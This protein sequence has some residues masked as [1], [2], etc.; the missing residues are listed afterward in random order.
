IRVS[1]G[2]DRATLRARLVDLLEALPTDDPRV[3]AARRNLANAL[4]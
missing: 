4:Y 1:A 3:L 2:D